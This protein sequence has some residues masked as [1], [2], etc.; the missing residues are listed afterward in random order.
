M[1]FVR[2]FLLEVAVNYPTLRYACNNCI[3]TQKT[4][5]EFLDPFVYVINGFFRNYLSRYTIHLFT[6]LYLQSNLTIETK[7]L[8]CSSLAHTKNEI[9]RKSS[10]LQISVRWWWH[11]AYVSLN[12]PSYFR[13]LRF[14]NERRAPAYV[15]AVSILQE[16]NGHDERYAK[17][18]P[19]K[20][21]RYTIG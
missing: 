4:A 7:I 18:L 19:H 16:I 20:C 3:F 15:R 5:L 9:I 17:P 1:V 14:R 6:L 8:S 21:M 2:I 11:N 10:A 13:S 12:F